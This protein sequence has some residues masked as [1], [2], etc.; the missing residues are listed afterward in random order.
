VSNEKINTIKEQL[1]QR[2]VLD[3]DSSAKSHFSDEVFL[4]SDRDSHAKDEDH[5]KEIEVRINP[6]GIAVVRRHA[7]FENERSHPLTRRSTIHVDDRVFCDAAVLHSIY[8]HDPIH[9]KEGSSDRRHS[10][11]NEVQLRPFIHQ[12]S[13][14]NLAPS[15]AEEGTPVPVRPKHE[16][17][18]GNN[19]L[20][21]H[22][23]YIKAYSKFYER[24]LALKFW[25]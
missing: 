18:K 20:P 22:K 15:D 13:E 3:S 17:K 14:P 9:V 16:F 2:Q 5:Y 23:K 21:I 19:N 11:Q 8:G 24:K 10:T 4:R 1:K 6:E 12:K 7:L 25:T